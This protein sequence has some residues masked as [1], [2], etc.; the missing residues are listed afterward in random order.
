LVTGHVGRQNEEMAVP[1]YIL[2]MEV[3]TGTF[4]Q[5][6]ELAYI[7]ILK[8]SLALLAIPRNS[9]PNVIAEAKKMMYKA[10]NQSIPHR[11]VSC[12]K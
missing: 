12:C 1:V 9:A 3:K 4:S 5:K 10:P 8:N 7:S 11:L 6:R 2:Q